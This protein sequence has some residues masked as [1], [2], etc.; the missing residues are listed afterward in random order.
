MPGHDN[1]RMY[2]DVVARFAAYPFVRVIRGAVPDSFAQGFPDRI[3][4]AH[5]D[6]N[7][8]VPEAAALEAVLPRLS[9]GGAIIFD[10]YGWWGYSAQKIALD[11]IVA[12]H[13]LKLLE[14]PTAQALL[15]KP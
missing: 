14:L 15:I 4:F 3:A 10:D 8:P 2:D 12:R 11:P 13:G 9:S 5:I 7:H 1:P 6:M